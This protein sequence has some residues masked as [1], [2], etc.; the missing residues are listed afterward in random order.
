MKKNNFDL[1]SVIE[2]H[3]ERERRRIEKEK[4]VYAKSAKEP[5]GT[6]EKYF[7]KLQVAAISLNSSLSVGDII[8]I[9]N[10]EEAIRQK[11]VS[12][13]IDRENVEHAESGDSIGVMVRCPVRA[14]ESVYKIII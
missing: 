6:V 5:I 2:E 10:D 13:Q 1:D 14:G 11:V 8:E 4:S 9:G 7:S 12:M 3:E